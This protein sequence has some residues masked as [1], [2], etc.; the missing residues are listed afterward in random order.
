MSAEFQELQ[1]KIA[2]V[3]KNR[4]IVTTTKKTREYEKGIYHPFFSLINRNGE[5]L[6]IWCSNIIRPDEKGNGGDKEIARFRNIEQGFD[7]DMN[8]PR[9]WDAVALKVMH[10]LGLNL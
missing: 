2:E 7:T 9:S 6:C 5:L 10:S 8:S 1:N 3:I 4:T